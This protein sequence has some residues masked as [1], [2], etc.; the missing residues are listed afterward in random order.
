MSEFV[1]LLPLG[2]GLLFFAIG[3]LWQVRKGMNRPLLGICMIAGALCFWWSTALMLVRSG[4]FYIALNLLMFVIFFGGVAFFFPLP[5]GA[6]RFN[7]H[8][9]AANIVV[10]TGAALGLAHVFGLWLTEEWPRWLI[11][12]YQRWG[13]HA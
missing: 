8:G 13:I 4:E 10:W 9:L 5:A 1:T 6:E 11:E 12:C 2:L 7:Q 3:F